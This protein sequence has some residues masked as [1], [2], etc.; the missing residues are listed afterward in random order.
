VT[1][2]PASKRLTILKKHV[3]K[4]LYETTCGN[5]L[6][7]QYLDHFELVLVRFSVT[8]QLR[9]A[10]ECHCDPAF[11]GTYGLA[12]TNPDSA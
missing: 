5:A 11:R 10:K 3:M 6:S 1:T 12:M 9:G 8:L 2:S 4:N 7:S